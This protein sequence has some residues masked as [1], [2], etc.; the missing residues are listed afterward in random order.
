MWAQAGAAVGKMLAG[1]LSAQAGQE[2]IRRISEYLP[3]ELD[4]MARVATDVRSL[5]EGDYY[6]GVEWMAT[7]AKAHRTPEESLEFV[8]KAR[9]S[10]Y[11]AYGKERSDPYRRTLVE[12]QIGLC[13]SLLG[14]HADAKNFLEAAYT[15]SWEARKHLYNRALDEEFI[16]FLPF[17]P[18]GG[19]PFL[20]T[21]IFSKSAANQ[22]DTWLSE[23]LNKYASNYLYKPRENFRDRFK[24]LEERQESLVVIRNENPGLMLKL[25]NP[26]SEF[27]WDF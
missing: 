15:S 4:I 27:K 12:Y 13:W 25:C 7:A 11:S 19:P 10:F 14:Q 23:V 5:K 26:Y 3:L 22:V 8:A 18:L 2:L 17:L 16:R 20:L 24:P 21:E 6:A 1:Q 9:D